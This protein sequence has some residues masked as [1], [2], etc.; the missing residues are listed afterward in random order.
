MLHNLFKMN[1]FCVPHLKFEILSILQLFIKNFL[2]KNEPQTL[3]SLGIGSQNGL[4][5]HSHRDFKS[6]YLIN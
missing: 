2:N 3:S 6:D 4:K 5:L 1:H